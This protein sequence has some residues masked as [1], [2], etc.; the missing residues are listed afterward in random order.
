MR[1]KGTVSSCWAYGS[2]GDTE[3]SKRKA[4]MARASRTTNGDGGS[5]VTGGVETVGRLC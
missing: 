1:L 3:K 4:A 2:W 5:V